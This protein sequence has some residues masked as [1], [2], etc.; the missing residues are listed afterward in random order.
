LWSSPSRLTVRISPEIIDSF[1]E[2]RWTFIWQVVAKPLSFTT[3]KPVILQQS[4]PSYLVTLDC[5][6]GRRLV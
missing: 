3:E 1:E 5:R 4:N 2:S 6:K